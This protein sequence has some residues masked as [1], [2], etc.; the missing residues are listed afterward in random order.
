[1]VHKS[2]STGLISRILNFLP[3]SQKESN[4]SQSGLMG[5]HQ[6]LNRLNVSQK[7]GFGYAVAIGIAMCGTTLG[8]FI[9]DRYRSEAYHSKE[10]AYKQIEMIRKLQAA[11][12]Q[13]RTHQQHFIQL[14]N[15]PEELKNEYSSFLQHSATISQSWSQMQF[16]V[17]HSSKA[18]LNHHD[19]THDD[20]IPSLLKTYRGIPEA[21]F[22]NIRKVLQQIDSSGLGSPAKITAARKLLQ[23]FTNSTLAF[24]FNSI[25]HDLN[26][27]VKVSRDDYFKAKEARNNADK[28][29]F[30]VTSSSMLLS[31]TLAI[32]LAYYISVN[33]SRPL[34][35]LTH[36]A[37]EVT[38]KSNFE[39]QAS[40]TT[41]DE[42]GVLANS[43]NQM[44]LKVKQLLA[45]QMDTN[46]KLESY[47]DSLEE[48]VQR[49]TQQLIEKNLVLE[50]T[51]RELK[52]TQSQLI[53][54]EKMSSLGQLVAGIAHEINNPVNF[55]HGNLAHAEQYTEDILR[56]VELYQE[57]YPEPTVTIQ[58]EVDS[59][60]LEFI[61]KDLT[62][63]IN[64]MKI[65]SQR[66][67]EIVKS[68]R[69]FSRVDQAEYKLAN[70]HEG[71]DS[72]LMIL[73][74]RL[75]VKPESV[76]IEV[77]K[78][79]GELPQVKCYP[80][81][82]N[83]VFMNLLA[84][85]I[86][87]LDECNYNMSLEEAQTKPSQIIISTEVFDSDSVAVCISD[88]GPGIPP[89]LVSQLF[90]PFFTTKPVGK[91]TG[92]GLSISYQIVVEKHHGEL[93][94]LSQPGEGTKFIV[95][96]PITQPTIS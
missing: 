52:K 12:L 40:V 84:N 24:K 9:S 19:M 95:K 47:N 94:C 70:I 41:A 83:Q 2:E 62:K 35:D 15:Q 66:I 59:I 7:I 91:G 23:D 22:Q 88:N 39:L 44:I 79:Y 3:S 93:K 50:N 64:S 63:L 69:N 82:L 54:T 1:M 90:D 33:I 56:L 65:G 31:T 21:Y 14:L 57:E 61:S 89:K 78:E 38:Q 77:I 10:H 55:I 5:F 16:L 25:S 20:D 75:K 42:V 13:A 6:C 53:Q 76:G 73:Q 26:R 87:A 17:S 96:I 49:R 67:R 30:W 4:N 29:H 48:E 74:N 8:V 45:E 37:Q 92:L 51:L 60:D 80:G 58:E 36:I 72:T 28:L 85:A 32:L 86:D 27:L 11:I 46:H 68:L 34:K 18:N 43:F 81:Q 71:I